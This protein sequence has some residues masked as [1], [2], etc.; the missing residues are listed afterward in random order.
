[1]P[2]Y[3]DNY[4]LGNLVDILKQI[5]QLKSNAPSASSGNPL[6]DGTAS[7]GISNNYSREDHVHPSDT[8]KANVHSPTFTGTPTAPTASAG[9][10][11]QQVATTQFVQIALAN[12]GYQLA[13]IPGSH[14][15]I[16]DGVISAYKIGDVDDVRI[17]GNS[18][19]ANGVAN[20]LPFEGASGTDEG[21]A[22]LVPAPSN[23]Q[24]DR[25]L[26]A[27]GTWKYIN[28]GGS[29][30]GGINY[31]KTE[32][33]TGRTWIDG[34]HIY[35]L[36]LDLND[37]SPTPLTTGYKEYLID[38]IGYEIDTIIDT[39][40]IVT[41]Y[42]SGGGHV[43]TSMDGDAH[44]SYYA[45]LTPNRLYYYVYWYT[46]TNT[47]FVRYITIRYIKKSYTEVIWDFT[48]SLEA[49]NNL[50]VFQTTCTRDSGGLHLVEN[51]QAY[52]YGQPPCW[53]IP[54]GSQEVPDYDEWILEIDVA[55][56]GSP[57]GE[58]WGN[59]FNMKAGRYSFLGVR[60]DL[61]VGDYIWV[62]NT[63]TALGGANATIA[64]GLSYFTGHTIKIHRWY[65]NIFIFRDTEHIYTYTKGDFGY[66]DDMYI[67]NFVSLGCVSASSQNGHTLPCTITGCR[68][69]AIVNI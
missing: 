33:D 18:I 19:V 43:L 29:G 39:E 48:K 65:D 21:T 24:E 50:S 11:T 68:F 66:D 10:A 15:R 7:S 28:G 32:Q 27:D 30:G 55:S 58:N 54:Q 60:Y 1:M 47:H 36:T 23:W 44:D 63:Q 8:S 20:L 69:K 53:L 62:F 41:A 37:Y 40:Q 51:K 14:I 46:D 34:R 49:T 38:I 17:E 16:Q 35:Q 13:L 42:V 6:M 31:S 22:G 56:V 9:T 25:F 61:D 59:I 5:F 2:K 12:S 52:I 57:T 67:G 26:C 4:G 45:G 64:T 3:L